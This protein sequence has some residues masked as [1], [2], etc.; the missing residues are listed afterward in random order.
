MKAPLLPA[1]L[2]LAA[3]AARAQTQAQP[4]AALGNKACW[5]AGKGAG[6]TPPLLVYFR[7]HLEQNGSIPE[8]ERLA[9]ARQAFKFYDLRKVADDNKLVVLVTGSS[10]V[11][12]TEA[13]IDKVAAAAGVRIGSRVLATHSGGN[14]GFFKSLPKLG[15]VKRVVL[16]DTFY[17]GA[18]M[19]KLVAGRIA[20]GTTCTGFVTP[21]NEARLKERFLP[22]VP[23]KDCPLTHFKSPSEHE[24]AA[25]RC[26]NAFVD[27]D[28]C[29]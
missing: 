1:L 8:A 27:R 24:E 7:G 3:G 9:S 13:D 28:T 23:E 16:L 15:P 12:I 18:D 26:L 10:D 20:G 19:T 5:Y 25:Q 6:E 29:Q 22:L 4:C 17:F 2:L 14:V 11:G 21:H